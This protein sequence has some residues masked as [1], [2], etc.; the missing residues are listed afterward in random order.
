LTRR[1]PESATITGRFLRYAGSHH[2]ITYKNDLTGAILY[3]HHA[4]IDELDLQNL[5]GDRGPAAKCLS[6]VISDGKPELVLRQLIADLTPT[7]TPWLTERLVSHQIPYDE[8]S[9][10]LGLVTERDPDYE[11]LLLVALMPGSPAERFLTDKNV[12][13]HY[14]L[15]INGIS[16]RSVTNIRHILD[17][18]HDPKASRGPAHLS[19]I[20]ILFGIVTDTPPEPEH[21]E[22]LAQD[23][24]T[25]RVVWSLIASSSLESLDNET[26]PS[27]VARLGSVPLTHVHVTGRGGMDPRLANE[28][29]R[30]RLRPPPDDDVVE[31]VRSIII[32]ALTFEMDIPLED[33]TAFVQSIMESDLNP[34]C[35]KFWHHAMKDPTSKGKW[36]E[37]MFKHL[38]SCYA[39][40]TFG[41]PQIPPAD[42]TVLPAVIVLKMVINAIKQINAHKV[43]VCVHGG[44]QIQGQAFDES[45]A[46]TV[47]GRSIKMC[48][49]IA[50]FPV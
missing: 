4:A 11:R 22:F 24:A 9:T 25:A 2:I 7:I 40:G 47:L 35:P 3:A 44:H 39:L 38:E 37:T 46:H 15:N 26:K 17:N 30:R 1:R 19:G 32:S 49:A 48:V 34:V 13:G 5:P 23:H 14:I 16:I 6:G 42:V 27:A 10:V 50:C 28:E 31:Y 29:M 41:P 21:I 36:I 43:R 8:T 33:I 12:I 45:F 18:Y 20:T